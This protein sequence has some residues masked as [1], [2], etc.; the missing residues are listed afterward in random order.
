MCPKMIFLIGQVDHFAYGVTAKAGTVK[1]GTIKDGTV[2]DG[3][4]KDGT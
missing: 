4:M 2:K 1:D 3:T